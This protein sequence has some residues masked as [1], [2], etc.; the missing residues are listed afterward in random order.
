MGR[1]LRLI[2]NGRIDPTPL[3]THEFTFDEVDKAFE[4]MQTKG[5]GIIKPLVTF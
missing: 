1:L 5:D 3:T 2:K 4:L